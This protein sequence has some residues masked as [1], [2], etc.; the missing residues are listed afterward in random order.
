MS[1]LAFL[2]DFPSDPISGYNVLQKTFVH[3]LSHA[4]DGGTISNDFLELTGWEQHEGR[5]SLKGV[6]MDKVR[7]TYAEI[8]K[9]AWEG[10]NENKTEKIVAALKLNRDFGM[11]N[12]F[13]TTYAMITLSECFAE[14]ASHF[15]VDPIYSTYMNQEVVLWFKEHFFPKISTSAKQN[16]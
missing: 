11:A 16:K 4:F 7:S 1:D 15:L 8:K 9:L 12:G 10:L 2:N 14:V 6:D 5:W 3:E 13:P